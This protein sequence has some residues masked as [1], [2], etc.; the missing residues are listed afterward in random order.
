[1][2]LKSTTYWVY[3]LLCENG[4]YYCGYT[5]D[6]NSRF[7]RHLKGTDDCKYTRSFKPVAIAQSWKING[8]RADAMRVERYIKKL[9]RPEKEKLINSPLQLLLDDIMA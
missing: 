9:S 1:M 7:Q 2:N 8:S 4:N 5:T 3:I 6:L